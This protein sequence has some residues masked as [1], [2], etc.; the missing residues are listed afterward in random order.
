[1]ATKLVPFPDPSTPSLIFAIIVRV[2]EAEIDILPNARLQDRE[3]CCLDFP[4]VLVSPHIFM[5]FP[6]LDGRMIR[7]A[8]ISL[9]VLA[10]ELFAAP[11]LPP[12]HKPAPHGK[13]FLTGAT[14]IPRPG[15]TNHGFAIIVNNGVI[16]AVGPNIKPPADARIWD[17]KGT[18]IYPGFIDIYL[19]LSPSTLPVVTT[20]TVPIEATSR[21]E[22]S[23]NFFGV[24]GQATDPG[25]AGPSYENDRITPEKRV[26][27]GMAPDP[28]N[29]E[30]LRDLG[31]TAANLIPTKGILRG[32]SAFMLLDDS[33]PN[34]SILRTDV[35]Q[36][37]A[38]EPEHGAEDAYPKSL[39]GVIAS[40]RQVLLDAQHH[41]DFS[42][43]LKRKPQAG[44]RT[45]TNPALD[46][47]QPLLAGT[48]TAVFEPGSALMVDRARRLAIE[49][50]LKPIIVASGQEWR[51]P[52]L[53]A[54]T[55][56]PFIVPLNFSEPPKLPDPDD[57]H[58][59]TLDQLRA[60]DWASEN[61]ALLRRQGLE[62]SLTMHGLADRK[63]FHNKLLA[64]VARGL[65]EKDALAALTTTPAGLCGLAQS[66]GT[67]EKDKIANF[68][69]VAGTNYFAP[70]A[71]IHSVWIHG[72]S[73]AASPQ[74]PAVK[75]TPEPAK[76][77]RPRIAKAPSEFRGPI[78]APK[79]V[80]VSNAMIWTSGPKGNLENAD[81]IIEAGKFKAVG[82]DLAAKM[83]PANGT[84]FIN[85]SGRHVTSG[86]VDAHNHSMIL[87]GV[88]EGTLPSTAMVRISDVVNSESENI[89]LQLA[90][91]LTT[92]NLLHGS[93]N[94]IGGQNSVIKL[95]HGNAPA[96]LILDSA[97]P[98]IKFALGENVK[99][100]NWG[101]K[102]TTRFP[103]TRMGVR[104]FIQNRFLAAK[105]YQHRWQEFAK[106]NIP[107]PRRDLE[108]EAIVEILDGKRKIHCHSYR[109]D[110][111]LVFLRLMEEFK[112]QVGTLQHVLE[113]YKIADE[114][115]RHG[116]GASCFSDWWAYKYEVIDAMPYAGALMHKRGATV[117][118]NSD[119][120]D[121]ARRLNLE[122]AKAV[123]YGGVAEQDALAFVTINPARQL[124][125]DSSVGSIEPGKD[126]DFVLWSKSPL[127]SATLCLETW[128]DGRKYFDRE[129]AGKR[130]ADLQSERDAL[131][132]SAK[133]TADAGHGDFN[134]ATIAFFRHAIEHARAHHGCL[135]CGDDT[136]KR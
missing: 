58:Q 87:G 102:K 106:G 59:V 63:Q 77:T 44:I 2:S 30:S 111:I 78:I 103:Q 27:E 60:W 31:F 98:G 127:D 4:S 24:P 8:G 25:I 42:A 43:H 126:A 125:I 51:R 13:H 68:T 11:F 91:G 110:E 105:E 132:A 47:L 49:F 32:S 134:A 112:V 21:V 108:L 116:A 50:N 100:S 82:K 95:R 36:H 73:F 39:M 117:S 35:F 131:I 128:I 62:I 130:T 76:P 122:A 119:S 84:V 52:E 72:Q 57:W 74:K 10:N 88:N 133:A 54:A 28:K 12:G 113:G 79:F 19:T 18:T 86:L 9:L 124:R 67:I 66:L 136:H 22:R 114:I 37:F 90:G 46:S 75:K 17:M 14:L 5:F 118:F 83:K 104:T 81:I 123:K 15:E 61:P 65:S 129:L 3:N 55:Q 120:S 99:Q 107:P 135:D 6:K 34:D 26:M 94:P 64:A 56:C 71:R 41:R 23:I 92:A 1:M 85:G 45:P 29:I 101:D 93:A 16:E 109:Q 33:N 121:L 97:P 40:T 89:Y 20:M 48:M 69:V 96:D 80:V 38:F 115:A 53:A 70:E 7:V